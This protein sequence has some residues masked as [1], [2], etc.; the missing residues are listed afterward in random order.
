MLC[1]RR[2]FRNRHR[3]EI[4][5]KYE[6]IFNDI[7]LFFTGTNE[8]KTRLEICE[9]NDHPFYIGVQFHPEF[10]TT[11]NNPHPLFVKFINKIVILS[12]API[13]NAT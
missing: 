11:Q 13:F 8:D 6:K 4:N 5:K 10:Q 1:I 7:N 3:Y 2:W 9:R 12:D